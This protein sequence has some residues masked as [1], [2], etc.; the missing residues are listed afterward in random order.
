MTEK[1]NISLV[2]IVNGLNWKEF[3]ELTLELVE[4][5]FFVRSFLKTFDALEILDLKKHIKF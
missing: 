2:L 1:C 4:N 3:L 5:I